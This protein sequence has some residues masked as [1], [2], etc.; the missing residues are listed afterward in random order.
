MYWLLHTSRLPLQESQNCE[1]C[2][3][4]ILAKRNSLMQKTCQSVP[5]PISLTEDTTATGHFCPKQHHLQSLCI[6]AACLISPLLLCPCLEKYRPPGLCNCISL[7]QQLLFKESTI[8][9]RR[10]ADSSFNAEDLILSH[11]ENRSSHHP[12]LHHT[13]LLLQWQWVLSLWRSSA[14][15]EPFI[16]LVPHSTSQTSLEASA[17]R[18]S[19]AAGRPACCCWLSSQVSPPSRQSYHDMVLPTKKLG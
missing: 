7:L 11:T 19:W 18:S 1:T 6:S 16:L 17:P 15:L 14:L 12:Q 8:M 5:K 2:L 3:W 9:Y 13:P 10:C 4:C